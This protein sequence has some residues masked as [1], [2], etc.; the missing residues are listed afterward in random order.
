M[1]ARFKFLARLKFKTLKKNKLLLINSKK[2]NGRN[3]RN[4]ENTLRHII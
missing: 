3:G 4:L 1:L 2:R